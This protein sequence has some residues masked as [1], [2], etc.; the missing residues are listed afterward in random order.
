V[1]SAGI[2]IPVWAQ[3]DP[4]FADSESTIDLQEPPSLEASSQAIATLALPDTLTIREFR[5]EGSTIYSPEQLDEITGF[6]D[7][8]GESVTLAELLEIVTAITQTYVEDGYLTTGAFLP[9]EKNQPEDLSQGIVTFQ[10]LEGRVGDINITGLNRLR[11]S[12]IRSRLSLGAGTPLNQ[13]QLLQALQLLQLDPLVTSLSAELVA[14]VEPG[15]SVLNVEVQEAPT[16]ILGVNTD[17]GRSPSVGSNRRGISVGDDNLLG[18]GD[19]ILVSY[20]NTAGSDEL[21]ALYEFPLNPMDGSLQVRYSTSANRIIEDPFDAVDI[22]SPSEL[23]EI[24]YRQP[25]IRKPEKEFS[26][27]LT[28]TFQQSQTT[29]LGIPFPD[30][31]SGSDIDGRT[32]VSALRFF[33]EYQQQNERSVLAARS[34][35]SIGLDIL[36]AT[37]NEDGCPDS[38]FFS[39]RGQAQ[40]VRLTAPDTLLVVRSDIQLAD[41]PLLPLEQFGLGGQLTVRGYRQDALITDNGALAS[42]EYR[43]PLIRGENSPGVLQ[44]IPFLDVEVGWNTGDN[45]IQVDTNTLVGTGLG[46]LW[47][48]GDKFTARIDYGFPLTDGPADRDRTL[49]EQGFYFS[50]RPRLP[51]QL[52]HLT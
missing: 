29:L 1:I 2:Q 13:Q 38:Q 11:P 41:Q 47:Q 36:D 35:F 52:I 3:T 15:S 49:Q 46:L 25:L 16:F 26:L 24:T 40:Y 20:T 45:L 6:A 12:Y 37:I 39:W 32:R 50:L 22:R 33:Q 34:Q 19:S 21:E 4:S 8:V 17:N 42:I 27:G 31:S 10:I 7:R 5:Y 18:F 30:L 28:G 51:T 48:Q 43:Y 14:D 23:Y 9:L 44:I